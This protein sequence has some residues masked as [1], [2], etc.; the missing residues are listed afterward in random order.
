[1]FRKLATLG[2]A[3]VVGISLIGAGVG[4][5]FTQDTTSSQAINVGTMNVVLSADGASGNNT[6]NISLPAVGPVGSTFVSPSNVVT[7]TNAGNI[8][9]NAIGLQ[10]TDSN[11]NATLQ[12]EVWVCFYSDGQIL[13]NEP[14]TTVETY[15]LATVAG[16]IAANGGTDTY[17]LR[18]YAGQTADAGCGATFTGFSGGTYNTYVGYTFPGAPALGA[19]PAAPS[20]TNPAQ[21]GQVI[22]NLK[23][24]YVG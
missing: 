9:I 19:N 1:M 5:T 4:A 20:L 21:G 10:L 16:P 2:V 14:L 17:N 24:T 3:S 18:L 15:G 22:V 12:S 23:L 7:I 13:V 11:N 8:P 6:A